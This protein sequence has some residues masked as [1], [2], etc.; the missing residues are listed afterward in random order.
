MRAGRQAKGVSGALTALVVYL[1]LVGGVAFAAVQIR[2]GGGA[3][4]CTTGTGLAILRARRTALD[5]RALGRGPG[6]YGRRVAR[7]AAFKAVR[8]W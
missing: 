7:R 3:Q 4:R 6:V 5:V 8:R 2:H 1:I